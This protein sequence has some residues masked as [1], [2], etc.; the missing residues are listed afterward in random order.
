MSTPQLVGSAFGT[1]TLLWNDGDG[2]ADIWVY[3][4]GSYTHYTYG[5]YAGWTPVAVAT[6]SDTAPR[7]LW[8]NADGRMSL[9]RVD[10]SGGFTQNTWGPYAGWTARGLAVGGDNVPRVML[11]NTNGTMSLWKVATDGTFTFANYGPYAGWT[12]SLIAAGADSIPRILWTNTDGSVS[13]WHDVQGAAG[14]SYQNYGPYPGYTPLSLA[15]DGSN[16]P[17]ILWNHPADGTTS[18][19]SVAP[20]GGFTYQNYNNPA[21]S[22]PVGIASSPS[23]GYEQLLY[24]QPGGTA[25]INYLAPDGSSLQMK[26]LAPPTGGGGGGTGGGTTATPNPHGQ[27]VFNGYSGGTLTSSD[28]AASSITGPGPLSSN[29]NIDAYPDAANVWGGTAS[30][31]GYGNTTTSV[32]AKLGGTIYASFKWQADAGYANSPT[33]AQ[34][35]V[36]QRCTA[37]WTMGANSSGFSGQCNSGLSPGHGPT[38]GM[39]EDAVSGIGPAV[40]SNPGQGFTISAC[41]PTASVSGITGNTN[42]QCSNG[43]VSFAY[44]AAAVTM[45]LA[46]TT[47]DANGIDNILVGQG[48]TGS[49]NIPAPLQNNTTYKWSV[50]GTTFQSWTVNRDA[51]NNP[52]NTTYI[53]G[54]GVLTNSTAHW[55]WN[56]LINANDTTPNATDRSATETASCTATVTPPTGQGT[57]FLITSTKSVSVQAPKWTAT[58]TGGYMQV[59]TG[60]P[61]QNGSVSLYAGP[62]AGQ[63]GGINFVA[64]S[65]TPSLFGKGS[66]ELVQLVT[67][68]LS[69][70]EYTGSMVPGLQHNDPEN[71]KNGLDTHYPKGGPL[72]SEGSMP[73][74]TNDSPSINV[75]FYNAGSAVMQHQFTDYLM[76]QPPGNADNGV[77]WVPQGTA[78]WGTNGNATRPATGGWAGYAAQYGS[79]AAGTVTAGTAAPNVTVNFTAGNT[80]P[81]WTRINTFPNF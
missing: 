48:A 74:Q 13:L 27:Y 30:F 36:I 14:Y 65:T 22:S 16:T 57:P 41:M 39:Y 33:P 76:Y 51:N 23:G 26:S 80:F 68:S 66:L 29:N 77:Q 50:S 9:W 37:S 60:A 28:A 25:V 32:Y 70:T 2:V 62:T 6:G 3:G 31:T 15:A 63:A 12:A 20:G 21:G 18:L 44:T 69:Y 59:N 64:T 10:A 53:D 19:W 52:I 46:G 42:Y 8:I 5:P 35:T 1:S 61:L 71:G 73:Y 58:E 79:D 72:Y 11:T 47:P 55:Y 34:V 67:P 56:D 24:T 38:S 43:T 4:S 75:Q 54:P 40:V 49:W 78:T 81:A 45:N 7:I 17:R